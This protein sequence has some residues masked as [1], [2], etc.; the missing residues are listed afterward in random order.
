[1][2]LS[3][4]NPA[5]DEIQNGR[6]AQPYPAERRLLP[7]QLMPGLRR[8]KT[9]KPRTDWQMDLQM[10]EVGRNEQ[11]FKKP[12]RSWGRNQIGNPRGFFKTP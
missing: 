12:R 9:E 4:E 3:I 2:T 1:L 10:Y 11:N 8:K 5:P 6:E 7:D